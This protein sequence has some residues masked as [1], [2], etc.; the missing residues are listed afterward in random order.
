MEFAGF[1]AHYPELPNLQRWRYMK[2]LLDISQPPPEPA[3]RRAVDMP[4][5][6]L[7]PATPWLALHPQGHGVQV[8][9]PDGPLHY[10]FVIAGTGIAVDLGLR[11]ELADIAPHVALWGQRFEPPAAEADARLARFPY[12]DAYGG[13]M[14]SSPGA[15]PWASRLF[16]NFRGA[17][18]S[19][20]PSSASNSNIRYTAPRIISGVTQQLFLSEADAVFHEFVTQQHHELAA[21]ALALA[22]GA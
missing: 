19:M 4:G 20:G 9:T 14:E 13:F 22:T 11:P 21:S 16:A 6:K 1:L 12:L 8:D 3:F 7:R 2:R 15:A 18:L 17:T 10:D 5:F